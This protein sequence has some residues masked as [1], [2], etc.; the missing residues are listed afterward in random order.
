MIHTI[1]KKCSA[2]LIILCLIFSF[3]GCSP[4]PDK[5]KSPETQ[6]SNDV[7]NS[8]FD[9]YVNELFKETLSSDAFSIH[10]FLQHP[11][12]YGITDYEV[13]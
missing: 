7:K 4:S 9:S 1:F 10:S 5:S 3:T 13:P 6:I 12:N 8:E 11:E 2:F